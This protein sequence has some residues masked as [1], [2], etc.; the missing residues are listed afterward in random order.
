MSNLIHLNPGGDG[1]SGG[2]GGLTVHHETTDPTASENSAAGYTL[3]DLW[4]NENTEETFVLVDDG[5]SDGNAVWREATN[6]DELVAHI[7][8]TAN[9]HATSLEQ[10]R[11]VD[12]AMTGTVDVMNLRLDGNT[13][14]ATNTDGDLILQPNGS[15]VVQIP[16]STV[17]GIAR[18]TLSTNNPANVDVFLDAR[19]DGNNMA[20]LGTKTAHPLAFYTSD[21]RRMII[22]AGGNM[23]IFKGFFIPTVAPPRA[24]TV[25]GDDQYLRFASSMYG[26]KHGIEFHE[27]EEPSMALIYDGEGQGDANKMSVVDQDGDK[28]LLTIFRGGQMVQRILAAEPATGDMFNGSLAAYIDGSGNLVFKRKDGGGAV[29]SGTVTLN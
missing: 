19:G 14:S 7:G 18:L 9:P 2:G 3:G 22:G 24:I 28:D 8:D 4:V 21:V 15:G 10:A 11:A 29:T 17:D 1:G 6:A 16:N 5:A 13:I 23:A 27:N 26:S 12:N 20:Q 25:Y